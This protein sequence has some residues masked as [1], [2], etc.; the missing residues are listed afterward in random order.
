MRCVATPSIHE[1]RPKFVKR[2]TL[3]AIFT[4][5]IWIRGVVPL[6]S[7]IALPFAGFLSFGRG[8]RRLSPGA[9]PA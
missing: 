8:P 3:D 6:V 2:Y 7:A 5:L 4:C 9:A 1:L